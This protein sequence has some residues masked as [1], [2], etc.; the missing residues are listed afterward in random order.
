MPSVEDL[1]SITDAA[2]HFACSRTTL[3]RAIKDGRLNAVEVGGRTMLV[4]DDAWQA[5]EPVRIGGRARML[6]E[7]DQ[8]EPEE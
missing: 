1:I 7:Q 8:D 3:Y 5:F 6:D 2:E 4:K